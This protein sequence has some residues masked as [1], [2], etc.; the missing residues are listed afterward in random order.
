MQLLVA[1]NECAMPSLLSD[2]VAVMSISDF[3]AVLLATVETLPKDIVCAVPCNCVIVCVSFQL[4][5]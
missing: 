4:L 3:V 2:E 1:I 5:V